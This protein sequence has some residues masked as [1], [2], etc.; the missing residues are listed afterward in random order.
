MQFNSKLKDF[1]N[2]PQG[3]AM[4]T[5]DAN[6]NPDYIKPVGAQAMGDGHVKIFIPKKNSDRTIENIKNNKL[7][8]LTMVSVLNY[9]AFQIKG[10]CM[11]YAEANAEEQATVE[12]YMQT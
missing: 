2:G 11:R 12:N 4:G 6:L 10:K 5:R 9:E 1:I 7:I 3:M 8:A